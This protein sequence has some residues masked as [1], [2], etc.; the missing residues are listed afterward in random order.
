VE[1]RFDRLFRTCAFMFFLV[2]SGGCRRNVEINVTLHPPD[3]PRTCAAMEAVDKGP[4]T[5]PAIAATLSNFG[6]AY[7]EDENGRQIFRTLEID[8]SDVSSP[9]VLP[10]SPQEGD[11]YPTISADW[12]NYVVTV[13]SLHG[14]YDRTVLLYGG[15]GALWTMGEVKDMGYR[16]SATGADGMVRFI[17][18]PALPQ[19]TSPCTYLETR[20][21][22]LEEVGTAEGRHLYCPT[23]EE[24]TKG[25]ATAFTFRGAYYIGLVDQSPTERTASLMVVGEKGRTRIPLAAWPDEGRAYGIPK[26]GLTREGVYAIL[27]TYDLFSSGFEGHSS[28]VIHLDQKG[29]PGDR[30]RFETPIDLVLWNGSVFAGVYY[31]DAD[32]VGL[33]R[34]LSHEGKLLSEVELFRGKPDPDSGPRIAWN[35]IRYGLTWAANGRVLFTTVDCE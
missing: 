22:S 21:I 2:L 33:F 1:H 9:I 4:G 19:W 27:N 20:G 25:V 17:W 15:D 26:V 23:A 35:G 3:A 18:T 5:A 13:S 16:L 7:P 32:Q 10:N 34:L 14:P 28:T 12:S 30:Y 31:R 29:A 6:L 24:P 11:P 8:G